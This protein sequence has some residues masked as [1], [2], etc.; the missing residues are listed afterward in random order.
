MRVR[1]TKEQRIQVLN[2]A[3]VYKIMQQIL[4]R[5][6]KIGRSKEHVWVVCLSNS[7][8]ILLIELSTLGTMKRSLIDATEVFS[9]AL[10]KRASKVILVH[11]HPSGNLTPSPEDSDV[12]DRMNQAGLFLDLPLIDHLIIDE[13]GYYSFAESGLLV[14]IRRSR[15]YLLPYKEEEER[16][17]KQGRKQGAKD[18][19]EEMARTMKKKGYDLKEIVEISKLSAEEIEKL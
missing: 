3:D 16:L 6:N 12:T 15:K 7:N 18:K 9:F 19:A 1:L 8:R 5:E 17:R 13:E 11:N 2:A 4:L 14:K 10:Q